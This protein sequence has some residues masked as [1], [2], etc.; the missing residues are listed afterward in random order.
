MTTGSCQLIG[1][2]FVRH[3]DQIFLKPGRTSAG[4]FGTRTPVPD[5]RPTKGVGMWVALLEATLANGY[6]A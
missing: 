2:P 1:Q 3:L 4:C 6:A 5:Q